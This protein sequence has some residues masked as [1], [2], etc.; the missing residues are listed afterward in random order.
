MAPDWIKAIGATPLGRRPFVGRRTPERPALG[1]VTDVEHIQFEFR[2]WDGPPLPF[3]EDFGKGRGQVYS[4]D[5]T[6]PIRSCNEVEVAKRLRRVR[7]YA[8]WFSGYQP[9]LVP[10]IWRPWVRNLA[11]DAPAWLAALDAEIRRQ[12]GSPR[13]GMPDVVAWDDSESLGSAIFIECKG[14]TE[15]VMEAQTD[16]LWAACKGGVTV[17]QLAVSVRPF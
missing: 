12:I 2:R 15:P 5:D 9:R 1:P 10:E 6:E 16:W 8:Y 17:D 11:D 14:P 7:R 4:L 13:G 3:A